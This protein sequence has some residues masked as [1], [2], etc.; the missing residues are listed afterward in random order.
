M[1]CFQSSVGKRVRGWGLV[2]PVGR[3]RLSCPHCSL[4]SSGRPDPIP[5]VLKNDQMGL[6][7]ASLD[8]AMIDATVAQR[9]DL[10]SERQTKETDE[11]RQKREE[12]AAKQANIKS[13]IT[14]TLKPFYCRL[15]DKQYQTVGQYDEH[16]NSVST[17]SSLLSSPPT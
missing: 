14:E 6:G 1:L 7:K 10:A 5:F 16:C 11:K 12:A 8:S 2:G 15:C 13:E 4:V 17:S 9:R 3:L